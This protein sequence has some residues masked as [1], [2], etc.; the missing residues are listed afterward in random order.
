MDS[1]SSVE[2]PT[3]GLFISE[4]VLNSS[5]S[6]DSFS[7]ESQ[8]SDDFNR[9][10]TPSLCQQA[11]NTN[12]PAVIRTMSHQRPS[13]S[14]GSALSS[15]SAKK[16][17]YVDD[18]DEEFNQDLV[19]MMDELER[20]GQ[21]GVTSNVTSSRVMIGEDLG[22]EFGA[23]EPFNRG[24]SVAR[25]QEANPSCSQTS[26]SYV[27]GNSACYSQS[28]IT[29]TSSTMGR[30]QSAAV[31][32]HLARGLKAGTIHKNISDKLQKSWDGAEENTKRYEKM[33]GK[34]FE[35]M[36]QIIREHGGP[37]LKPL[38]ERTVW[39]GFEYVPLLIDVLR[40]VKDRRYFLVI[41]DE[42][43]KFF[44]EFA[45][46]NDGEIYSCG[47]MHQ[48]LKHIFATL[49]GKYNIAVREK[50]FGTSGTYRARISNIWTDERKVNP[51]FGQ[52]KGMSEICIHDVKYVYEAIR[53]GVLQPK[54][55]P[56]HL[57]LVVQFI[58]LRLFSV[59]S[60][61]AAK[62]DLKN[63]NWKVYDFGPDEG[64]RY[65]ELNID[66]TK[67][68]KLKLGQWK[69]PKNYGKVKIRDNPEDP[70]FNAFE[71]LQ[72]YISKLPEKKGR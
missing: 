44:V 72:F 9:L 60:V 1:N 33:K 17:T 71:L 2:H 61:E 69:I 8:K 53:D 58:L 50:D 37:E 46:K 39:D 59:R 29:E 7:S 12:P 57:K 38:A 56:Y 19:T 40:N 52:A 21:A 63:V 34:D 26:Y 49:N 14:S 67:V 65:V 16:S 41:L 6:S 25:R 27:D 68:R 10:P 30:Y 54:E 45:K 22:R 20:S 70:V 47:T 36:M 15:V 51:T 66:I 3:V 4:S 43:L 55:K 31:G 28:T 18:F 13:M 48:K 42:C 5:D 11:V 64:K 24:C 23:D 32:E 35:R 62:L